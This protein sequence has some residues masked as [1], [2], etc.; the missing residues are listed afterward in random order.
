MPA[1]AD[2][3]RRDVQQSSLEV[4]LLGVVDYDAMLSLQERLVFEISGRVDSQGVLLLCEHPPCI[5]VGREGSRSQI[6]ADDHDLEACQIGVRWIARGGGA[7]VHAPGQLAIYPILP[8]DRLHCGLMEYRRRLEEALLAACHDVK[9]TAKRADNAP[10]LWCRDGQLAA[11][12]AAVKRWTTYHG[13]Y[14][15]VSPD[16]SFLQMVESSPGGERLT[17][18][19][20]QL[21]RPTKM[22]KVREAVVNH[23]AAAFGYERIHLYTNHPLLQRTIRKV[24]LHA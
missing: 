9:V 24:C 14:L 3:H 12:G 19:E 22:H 21:Q 5:S 2:N 7:F 8:L 18:V 4:H 17:S 10:G 11:F 23:I 13:A 16:P 6:L 15:N 1:A 20:T